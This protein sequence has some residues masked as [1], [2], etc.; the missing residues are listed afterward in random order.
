MDPSEVAGYAVQACAALIDA[1]ALGLVHRDIKPG[2]L[3]ITR[4]ADGSALV[5]V[6]DFGV[7]KLACRGGGL[8]ADGA[9]LGTLT[10]MAPEQIGHS[11]GVDG[12]A[13]IWSLGVTLYRLVTGALPFSGAS[14]ADL[15]GKI[16]RDTPRP[17]RA[18]CPEVPPELDAVVLR[19][20]EKR[21]ED[22]YPDAMALAAALN[23][24]VPGAVPSSRR[25][26][27]PDSGHLHP[28]SLAVSTS[29]RQ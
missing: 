5:K 6:L 11:A 21:L 19:C 12:R 10:Y 16:V 9:L 29:S 18:L 22:R 25:P 8:T 24:F 7:V 13:D 3:F 23:P 14:F 27:C 2:N 28:F 1:H 26:A 15:V 17:M 20:L 4:R